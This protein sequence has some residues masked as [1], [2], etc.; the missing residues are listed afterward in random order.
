M[1]PIMVPAVSSL[2][3]AA[4]TTGLVLWAALAF[5]TKSLDVTAKARICAF[6]AVAL[7]K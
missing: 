3:K 4:V 1:D 7:T 5:S 2:P 6:A